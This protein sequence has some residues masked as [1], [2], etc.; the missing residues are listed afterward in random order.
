MEKT[1]LEKLEK[2]TE[3][4]GKAITFALQWGMVSGAHHKQWVIDQIIRILLGEDEENYQMMI[5][6]GKILTGEEWDEG[7]AP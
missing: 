4:M 5:K 3:L 1:D 7:V 6:V 2:A